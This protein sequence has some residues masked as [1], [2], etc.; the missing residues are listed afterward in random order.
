MDEQ[1]A[2]QPACSKAKAHASAGPAT[3]AVC[4]GQ[5]DRAGRRAPHAGVMALSEK[6][7][8]PAGGLDSISRPDAWPAVSNHFSSHREAAC[9]SASRSRCST[10]ARLAIYARRASTSSSVSVSL[11]LGMPRS[12]RMPSSTTDLNASL[13]DGIGE[14][15][16]SG[17]MLLVF[18]PK[19]WQSRQ[20]PY[21]DAPFATCSSVKLS[22]ATMASP[23]GLS[24]RE[25]LPCRR[26]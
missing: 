7:C 17:T 1:R 10:R 20:L 11:Q 14:R 18:M 12:S 9:F 5:A 3:T 13:F 24:C 23:K 21:S 16:R 26:A 22:C 15:R 4:I 8:P 25:R 6:K 2:A 19:P